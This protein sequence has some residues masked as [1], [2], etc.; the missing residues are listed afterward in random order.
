MRVQ[1]Y[2]NFAVRPSEPMHEL[3]KYFLIYEGESTEPMYFDGIIINRTKLAIN[4]KISIIGVLRSLEDS[5]KSHPKF[6][7]S[8]ANDIQKQSHEGYITKE[9]LLKSLN[10]VIKDKKIESEREMLE[11]AQS[12]INNYEDDIIDNDEID[13]ILIDIYKDTIFENITQD[14]LNYLQRQQIILDYNPDIDVINLIVDRDKNNFKDS[15]YE[16]LVNQCK[17][18]NIHL[19]V[20]NPCFEVWLLMHFDEF[21]NLDFDK[22]LENKR[23]NAKDKSRKYSDK[24]LSNIIGCYNKSNLK[25]EDFIDRVD[26]AIER[27]KKYCENLDGL[28]DNVGSNVGLLISA[29]RT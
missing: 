16:K 2:N 3:P 28:K 10:D 14:I 5:S 20:S 22:L 6:A 15:Q 4:Q 23:I 19:Y 29:M 27:E 25:F 1:N 13:S 24:M 18:D 21:E 17:L 26:S 12:Y 8:I 9:N 7:L 11:K